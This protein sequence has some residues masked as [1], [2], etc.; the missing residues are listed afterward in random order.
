M[1]HK[2]TD[3]TTA[4]VLT[5]GV[6]GNVCLGSFHSSLFISS[7]VSNPL[8]LNGYTGLNCSH[9]RSLSFTTI[10]SVF[11][12]SSAFQP[13]ADPMVA[14]TYLSCIVKSKGFEYYS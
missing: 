2:F 6:S 8:L 9:H 5:F 3:L 14:I 12:F 4:P 10:V 1:T 11:P 7:I 13:F